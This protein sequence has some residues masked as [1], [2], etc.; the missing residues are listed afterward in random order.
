[1]ARAIQN[2]HA[3]PS[4]GLVVLVDRGTASAAEVL[5]AALQERGRA[6]LVGKRTYGK[7]SRQHIHQPSD[8]SGL[9]YTEAEWRTSSG[10]AIQAGLDP[11][12]LISVQGPPGVGPRPAA[13]RSLPTAAGLHGHSSAV[14]GAAHRRARSDLGFG[15]PSDVEVPL[16]HLRML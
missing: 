9:R 8:G 12:E 11:D 13:R 10:Q 5:A 16:G 14:S 2:A 3:P 6:D 4:G 15:R 1:M 7:G